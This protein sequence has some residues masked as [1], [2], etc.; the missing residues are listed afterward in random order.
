MSN[1]LLPLF[2]LKFGQKDNLESL[3]SG[4]LYMKNFNYFINLEEETG[5]RGQGDRD[6]TEFSLKIESFTLRKIETDEVFLSGTAER[7]KLF[8][9]EDGTKPVFCMAY[10]TLSDLEIVNQTDDY[11][12]SVVK[13]SEEMKVTFGESVLLISAGDFINHVET[14]LQAKGI[15]IGHGKANYVDFSTTLT[16]RISS[17]FNQEVTRFFWKDTFFNYQKEYRIVLPDID[18]EIDLGDMSSFMNIVPVDHLLSGR[19]VYRLR[20]Q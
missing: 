16:D 3:Q 14:T 11:V 5:I 9:K 12:E 8:S 18:V 7:T 1:S 19:I 6:E 20:Y 4:K 17:H 2:F 13:F 15:E 10:F